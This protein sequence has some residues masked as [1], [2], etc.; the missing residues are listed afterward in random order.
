MKIWLRCSSILGIL[1]GGMLQKPLP[2]QAQRDY[3]FLRTCEQVRRYRTQNRANDLELLTLEYRY[4]ALENPS[5]LVQR[6]FPSLL[7][8]I[9]PA[10]AS[11]DCLDTTVLARLAI[12]Q[13]SYGSV[14]REISGLQQVLCALPG[15]NQ[16][17]RLEWR[18]GRNAKFGNSWY[19]ANGQSA[20]FGNSW[21]YPN[22]QNAKFG[23]SW[24][25]PNGRNAK[26]GSF[27]YFPD[28]DRTSLESLLAWSCSVLSPFI[29][30]DRLAELQTSEGF[31]YDLAVVELAS[32]A[33][34]EL[35]FYQH[36]TANFS[37]F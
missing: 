29:C 4:C 11:Q 2:A 1:L 5:F 30:Q 18:N 21:Y 28:G 24:Y 17:R 31:W 9:P 13:D 15:T 22:G 34:N 20:K 7:I 27:W 26:F 37:T 32:R 8:A 3:G 35:E 36:S 12:A 33:F 6:R 23:R 10:S 16:S 19:Y 25:Y 14:A